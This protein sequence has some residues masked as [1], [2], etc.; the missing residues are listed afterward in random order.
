MI[1][2][3]FAELYAQH[4]GC[5][6]PVASAATRYDNDSIYIEA[7]RA[8]RS[9][10]VAEVWIEGFRPT[11]L[12]S[13]EEAIDASTVI[14]GMTGDHL[15]ALTRPELA[16][17]AFLLTALIGCEDEIADPLFEGNYGEAFETI[18]GCVDALI[19]SAAGE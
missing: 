7:A 10:G 18:E 13:V 4:V 12:W 19:A 1:R 11:T 8:L 14:F 5:P 17:R 15:T 9:R 16:G 6:L 2:S 3:A